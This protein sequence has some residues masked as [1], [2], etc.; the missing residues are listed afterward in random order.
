MIFRRFC[1][2]HL[3]RPYGCYTRTCNVLG[4]CYSCLPHT[5]R[6]LVSLVLRRPAL[7]HPPEPLFSASQL[8]RPSSPSLPCGGGGH[9]RFSESKTEIPCEITAYRPRNNR[10]AYP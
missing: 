6:R 3:A 5:L 7:S 8:L 9:A 2:V 1:D 10:D 4:G